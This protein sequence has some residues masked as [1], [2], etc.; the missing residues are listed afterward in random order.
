METSRNTTSI[1]NGMQNGQQ[2]LNNIGHNRL[3]ILRPWIEEYIPKIKQG[4]S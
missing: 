1:L 4:Q 2:T 3:I